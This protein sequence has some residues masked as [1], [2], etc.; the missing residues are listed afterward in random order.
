MMQHLNA[1]ELEKLFLQA[2]EQIRGPA[3][4]QDLIVLDGQEPRQGGGHSILA[5]LTVPSQHYLG[6]ALVD[7]ETN[8]IP[9]ARQLFHKLDLDGRKISLD[10]LAT[11]TKPPATPSWNT[12]LISC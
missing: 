3:P 8:E 12:A 10:A 9:V 4:V 1:D 5:A 6:S 7:T 2:Q 11:G